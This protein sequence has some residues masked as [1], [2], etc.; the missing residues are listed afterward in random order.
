MELN[1]KYLKAGDL[2]VFTC[3]CKKSACNGCK[4]TI[5]EEIV[6][7]ERPRVFTKIICCPCSSP[8]YRVGKIKIHYLG[9]SIHDLVGII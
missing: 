9:Y 1:R 4:R 8:D 3:S 7:I 5:T 2:L 6:S